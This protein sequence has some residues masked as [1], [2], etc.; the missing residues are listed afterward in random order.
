[1]KKRNYLAPEAE[2]VVFYTEEELT[3]LNSLDI[4]E[5]GIGGGTIGGEISTPDNEGNDDGWI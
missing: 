5:P 3:N 1:M 2:L 4:G